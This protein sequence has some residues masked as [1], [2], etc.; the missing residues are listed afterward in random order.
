MFFARSANIFGLR[1]RKTLY[2]DM[3]SPAIRP[4]LFR[5]R[6]AH[7]FDALITFAAGESQNFLEREV[8]E[9]CADESELHDVWF[10]IVANSTVLNKRFSQWTV[11]QHA[12][13]HG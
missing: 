2:I 4:I 9:D 3:A 10:P 6:P 12:P 7:H 8:T 13:P 1:P 11:S 5:A